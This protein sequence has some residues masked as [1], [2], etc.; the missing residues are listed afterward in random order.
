MHQK[1]ADN[2][3]KSLPVPEKGAKI[4]YD[5][6]VIGLGCRVSAGGTRAF[7][8]NYRT[9]SGRERRFT[10]G[11]F[12]DW[13][14][15]AARDEARALRK[16]IDRGDDPMADL[17]AGREAPT[18]SEMCDRFIEEH[19]PKKRPSTQRDYLHLI[20]SEI[21]PSLRNVKV[22][23]VVFSDVD[24]LH[25]AI[26]KRGSPYQANRTVATLS[27]IFSMAIKWG[28]IKDN[29]AKGIERNQE[30]KR[31]RYLTGPELASLTIALAEHEDQQSPTYC[32]C[33]S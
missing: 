11:G 7:I 32:D 10:I 9:R 31:T 22:A 12:P 17:Q 28:W 20:N 29:P 2:V 26:T 14:I 1:L 25:R 3:I 21:R 24:K 6:E 33:C 15:G 19:L 18:V 5:S 4:Y 23:D 16:M 13:K 27:K 8:L 30:I